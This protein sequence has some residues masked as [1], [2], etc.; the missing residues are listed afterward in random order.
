MRTKRSAA[1]LIVRTMA[2][3]AVMATALTVPAPDV[4]YDM[5]YNAGVRPTTVTLATTSAT[6][7]VYYDM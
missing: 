3:G 1:G 6:P 4:Y 7:D 5:R 2:T